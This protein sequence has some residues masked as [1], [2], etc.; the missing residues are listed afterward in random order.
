MVKKVF[1]LR[2][3]AFKLHSNNRGTLNLSIKKPYV[4]VQFKINTQK[5]KYSFNKKFSEWFCHKTI[6]PIGSL[7][8]FRIT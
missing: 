8:D 4:D 1:I 7:K 6:K 2:Y 5:F 3:K